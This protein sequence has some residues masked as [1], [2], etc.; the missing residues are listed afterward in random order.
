MYLDRY[1]D[2]IHYFMLSLRLLTLAY[3]QRGA[4]TAV[5]PFI[6]PSICYTDT[7]TNT[8]MGGKCYGPWDM[9]YAICDLL[10]LG[11]ERKRMWE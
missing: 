2:V 11:R 10:E 7:N 5:H 1:L 4:V 6:H 8:D 3:F 9:R